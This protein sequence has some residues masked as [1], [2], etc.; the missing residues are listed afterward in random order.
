MV[1]FLSL[2]AR[3]E[4]RRHRL[5]LDQAVLGRYV[6]DWERVA[7]VTFWEWQFLASLRA[8]LESRHHRIFV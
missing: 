1:V 4:G 3:S 7:S 2:R 5:C 8:R 6:P